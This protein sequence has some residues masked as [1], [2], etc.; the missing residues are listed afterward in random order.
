MKRS[1]KEFRKG[2]EKENRQLFDKIILNIDSYYLNSIQKEEIYEELLGMFV[3]SENR[4]EYLSLIIGPDVNEFCK[5]LIKNAKR[6]TILE[7]VI[8]SL[9][10]ISFYILIISIVFIASYLIFRYDLG[11]YFH[12][13]NLYINLSALTHFISISIVIV[14]FQKLDSRNIFNKNNRSI[15]FL[16]Y[17][18][19]FIFV[20]IGSIEIVDKEKIVKINAIPYFITVALITV[21]LW[22]LDKYIDKKNYYS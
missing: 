20:S 13:R 4:N 16:V 22:G 14:V 9:Y 5:A 8:S 6:K 21:G 15:I 19:I 2:L 3:E 11:L 18:L 10:S 12:G 1:L 7:K 17:M